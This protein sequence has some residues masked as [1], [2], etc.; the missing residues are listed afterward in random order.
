MHSCFATVSPQPHGKLL[1]D[2]SVT[3]GLTRKKSFGFPSV[4]LRFR[5]CAIWATR[6]ELDPRGVGEPE[7][8]KW[9]QH[10]VPKGVVTEAALTRK[11]R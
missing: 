7:D 8:W 5:G 10:Y 4:N 6:G 3:K 2:P 9:L 11:K 1:N